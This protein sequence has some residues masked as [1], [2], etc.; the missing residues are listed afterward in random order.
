MRLFNCL[1]STL[2]ILA[3]CELPSKL[4]DLPTGGTTVDTGTVGEDTG[5]A[6]ANSSGPQTI[7]TGDPETTGE[8]DTTTGVMTTGGETTTEGSPCEGLDEAACEAKPGCMTYH[9]VPFDFASCVPGNTYLGC[10]PELNCDQAF[11]A[12]CRDGTEID[13]AY[14]TPTACEPPGFSQCDVAGKSPCGQSCEGMNEAACA[15]DGDFCE[16]IHGLPHVEQ[17]GT[18]CVD[19]DPQFIA[20]V[21]MDGACPPEVPTVCSTGDSDEKYDIPSGCIPPEFEKCDPMGA[22]PCE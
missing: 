1:T 13:E 18:V 17:D 10:G 6:T 15:F 7:S 22:Q 9:G 8:P 16:P 19:Q 3:A 5:E 11:T 12:M 4:G 20:C 2:F 21:L 14:L